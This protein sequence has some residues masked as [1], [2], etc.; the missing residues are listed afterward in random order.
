MARMLSGLTNPTYALSA[1]WISDGV[2]AR[3]PLPRAIRA[4]PNA[5]VRRGRSVFE[6]REGEGSENAREKLRTIKRN[7]RRRFGRDENWLA[8]GMLD[9][10]R[11][12]QCRGAFMTGSIA[13]LMQPIVQLRRSGKAGRQRKGDDQKRRKN[14]PR[15]RH[16]RALCLRSSTHAII[17]T[18]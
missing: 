16:W 18:R 9:A 14:S 8:G 4:N 12:D 6:T 2:N 17:S 3:A 1:H 10:A 11:G 5:S 15:R 7:A 13:N